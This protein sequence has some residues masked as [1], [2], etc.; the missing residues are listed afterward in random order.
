MDTKVNTE[1]QTGLVFTNDK[2]IGCNKCISVCPVITAN[3]LV[4]TDGKQRIEVDGD[5][6]VGC[7]ACFDACEHNAR[8][9]RD[10]TETFF[11]DLQR[12]E[13][14]SVLWAPA[15][16]ANYPGEYK[17]ILGGLKRAG[18]NRIISISFGADITTWGY[19]KYITEHNFT[20][21]I[22]QPCP[23]IVN[24]IEHYI[25]ELIPSLV[26]IHSP[27][28]CGA[29]YAKKYLQITDKLA[30]ISP[31]IAKKSEISDPNNH[32]YV[33]Y[34]VT[35]DHLMNYARKHDI[36]AE[37]AENEIE[38]GLGSIYPMP[39]GLKENV[40]WFCGED[41]F[42]RQIEGE[43]HAYEYLKKYKERVLAGKELPFMVDALN[44]GQGCIYGTGVEESKTA[45]DD[46]LYELQKI[47]EASK[48]KNRSSA[49]GRT[50][51]PA[52]RLKNLNKQFAKLDIRDFM[53]EYT[54]K[55]KG[56]EIET[57]SPRELENIFA[58]MGKTTSDKQ[59]INCSACGYATC[60]EMATAIHNGCNNKISCVHYIKELAEQE[61]DSIANISAEMEKKNEQIQ[62]KNHAI[63]EMVSEA[64][65]QFGTL[66]TS[67]TEMM[68][69]NNNNA[70]ESS[71]IS[72][73]MLDVV[74]FCEKMQESFGKINELL[75]QMGDNN[76]NIAQVAQQ[77][78]L[79]SLNASIEAARAGTAGKGFAV[80]ATEIKSLSES[81]RSTAAESDKNKDEILD[82]MN[83]LT[84]EA[85]KL[86]Q[87]VDEVNQRI[88]NLAAST[89]EI[90]A[91]ANLI[92]EI[93]H[94]LR[95]KFD[96]ISSL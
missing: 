62:K 87:V 1:K 4:E 27:L 48:Q 46:I 2:C 84:G 57:P 81:S 79:L 82:A 32:G 54:D 45:N 77:T 91:S 53:R 68:N 3:H 92:G 75:M 39:G 44:C 12:G 66:H 50:L 10:D 55:S 25:P 90:A 51:S 14:I 64:N 13:Q 60:K 56:C 70:E 61:K 93:S 28:M 17:R 94:N 74:S 86:M 15:F 59:K 88:T 42:I 29:V 8:E 58:E 71:N 69:G 73:A 76:A 34:N 52:Q 78:N 20:G 24:Y 18:V 89:Q 47:K 63:E 85:K 23:A 19:I 41:I 21:G 40:Y 80:V 49:W 83:V 26:P 43:K 9:F 36:M 11:E 38:Y 7:G 72:A 65:D 35:F 30:F 5:K 6:C 16:A 67:I 96:T 22:S 95:N 33:S 31:C 37:P